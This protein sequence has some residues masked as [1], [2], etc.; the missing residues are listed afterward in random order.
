MNPITFRLSLAQASSGM[1]SAIF[2]PFYGAW[3]AWRGFPTDQIAWIMSAGY[4]LRAVLSPFCGIIADARNDRRE[5]MLV[6]YCLMFAG[7]ASMGI[8]TNTTL[9]GWAAVVATTSIGAITP[10]LESVCVRLASAYGYQYGRVR[11]WASTS[12]VVM[13][14]IGGI[15]FSLFGT[16][17]VAPMLALFAAC[18]IVTTL[19]LPPP[20][21]AHAR[22][23]LPA[24]LKQTLSEA[25]ELARSKIFLLFLVAA[26]LVQGSH[27]FYY[28]YGG[29][30]WR[31]QGYSGA[32]IGILYP[33]GV[34]AEICIL[35]FAQKLVHWIG[36]VRLILLGGLAAVLRWT[37]MA[38]DP[39][40]ALVIALQFLHGATFA[41]AH[42]GAMYFLLRTVPPRLA[43]TAQSL[44][45]VCNAGIFVGLATLVSGRLYGSYGGLA[46]LPMSLMGLMAIALTLVLGRL[47]H[48]RHL[49]ADDG[50]EPVYTI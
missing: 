50:A 14:V 28:S 49:I 22:A 21:E 43:A 40:L 9:I 29:L 38:F 16:G 7:Y 39:P 20:G 35:M 11:L 41:L 45:F 34:L 48:G 1:I 2:L 8:F 6:L 44:Y 18:S 15:C 3:L 36:P 47:W 37:V 12:F 23:K 30:H 26:S 27:A 24:A 42:I 33:L 46:Y 13:S 19:M 4:L 32:M 5:M 10:L 31:A 17:I 25:F